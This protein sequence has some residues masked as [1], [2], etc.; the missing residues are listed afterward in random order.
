MDY[1]GPTVLA[2][3]LRTMRPNV[4]A[5]VFREIASMIYVTLESCN[6]NVVEWISQMEMKRINIELKIPGAYDDIQFPMDIY[7]GAL[8]AK[9]KTFTTE[10][11]SMKQKWLLGTLP[12][13]VHIDTIHSV[14][15][16]YSNLVED[17]TWKK[18]STDMDKIVALTT[19][20]SQMKASIAKNNI[21]LTTQNGK[22]PFHS[23][24][25]R[26]GNHNNR[27]TPYT[28]AAWRLKK[29]G[30]SQTKYGIEWQWCTKDHYSGGVVHTGMYAHHKKYEHDAWRKDFDEKKANGKTSKAYPSANPSTAPNAYAKKLALSESLCTA[31]CTQAGLSSE[32]ADR[33]C[34]DACR[35][36]G[37]K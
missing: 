8:E 36:S 30:E 37:N 23:A 14:T 26:T 24:N 7:Q 4:R 27:N 13:L 19:L 32:V 28:V 2:L 33:L 29:K 6:N 1:D 20:V 21:A 16:L 12:N 25:P 22:P 17:G 11:Q 34:F 5:N 31:M 3:I 35:E 18:E 15:Q 9:C 10:V